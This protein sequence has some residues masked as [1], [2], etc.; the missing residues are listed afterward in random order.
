M[1]HDHR[2]VAVRFRY[3]LALALAFALALGT[4]ACSPPR[5]SGEEESAPVSDEDG[6]NPYDVPEYALAAADG[7]SFER[8]F[9]VFRP[10][11]LPEGFEVADVSYIPPGDASGASGMNVAYQAGTAVVNVGVTVGDIGEDT[12]TTAYAW[13]AYG[14][15]DVYED[16]WDDSWIA[17]FPSASE[18]TPNVRTVGVSTEDL[19]RILVGMELVEP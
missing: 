1:Y 7:A 16:A 12:P 6:A 11:W 5:E 17:L 18:F 14:S 19:E 2:R 13:G 3:A 8:P 15:A 10:T 9:Q 4:A